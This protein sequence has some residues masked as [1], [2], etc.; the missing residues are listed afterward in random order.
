LREIA[1]VA[2]R[3]NAGTAARFFEGREILAWTPALN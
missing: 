2:L 3:L 1:F